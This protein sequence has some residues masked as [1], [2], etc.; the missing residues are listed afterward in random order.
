MP[1]TKTLRPS[2]DA[3][4]D[5]K[6]DAIFKTL[7]TDNSKSGRTAL[8]CFLEAVLNAKVTNLELRPNEPG[9]ETL[10]D[11]QPRFD[12]TCTL[13]GNEVVE[14][15]MQGINEGNTYDKR[16]EYY[17]ARLLNHY[18]QKGFKW[19]EVPKAFQISVLNF[20]YD[21]ST[22]ISL[23]HYH[24]QTDDKRKLADRLNIIF[25]EL[26]KIKNLPDD[27]NSLTA[28]EKCCKFF[29]YADAENTEKKQFFKKLCDNE[30]G[31]MA[32]R[33][34]LLDMSG[35][36]TNWRRQFD[37]FMFETDQRTIVSNAVHKKAVET[38]KSAFKM[39]LSVEQIVSLTALPLE[40]VT[41]IQAEISATV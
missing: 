14:I 39:G 7:F 29:L 36:E 23:S 17:A 19:A 21:D 13:N 26:P 9:I 10:S 12:V 24:M 35:E 27:E 16:A 1:K 5:P 3:L 32:A 25:I 4:L 6:R 11:K 34:V 28:V 38:A 31:L 18:T 22:D 20:I 40:E 15:E 8:R 41:A 30:E 33:D 37:R 2:P